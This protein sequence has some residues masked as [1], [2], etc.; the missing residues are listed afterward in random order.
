M[1]V[2]EATLKFN[3]PYDL[4]LCGPVIERGGN[5]DAVIREDP[6]EMMSE[7]RL[8]RRV[9]T[10]IGCNTDESGPL[11]QVQRISCHL[12]FQS[13]L[14]GDPSGWLQPPVDLDL[15]CSA[16]LPGQ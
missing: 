9:P 2:L 14:Q 10:I 3:D 11:G 12:E 4:N 1:K 6:L 5:A 7:G 13:Q 15:G 16:I 8:A